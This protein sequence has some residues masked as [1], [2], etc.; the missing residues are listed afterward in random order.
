MPELPEVETIVQGLRKSVIGKRIKSVRCDGCRVFA[1]RNLGKDLAGKKIESVSRRGKFIVME[2]SDNCQLLI[3]LGM[4]G[5]LFHQRRNEPIDKHDHLIIDF[6][7]NKTQLRYNDQRKFGRIGKRLSEN[8]KQKTVN[9]KQKTVNCEPFTVFAQLGPEPLEITADEFVEIFRK[10]TGRIKPLL[11]NQKVI[12]GIGNI[13]SDEAL[14]EAKI[15][16]LTPANRISK[17]KLKKLHKAIQR[18]L[19]KAILAGGSS[20]DNYTNLQGERGFF[21]LEH[22]VYGREGEKC[23][24]CGTKIKRIRITQRSTHFCPKCQNA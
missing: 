9:G 3:H 7:D 15:H 4:T 20:V 14:F 10:R 6:S 21:Q 2:L 17:Q 16:P 5:G 23:K 13:Y 11:L 12:A 1:Q 22:K 8:S 18:I 19:K 24:R